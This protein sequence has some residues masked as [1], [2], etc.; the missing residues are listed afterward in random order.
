[1][2]L[3]QKDALELLFSPFWE[4]SQGGDEIETTLEKSGFTRR[5]M[6]GMWAT[7]RIELTRSEEE[8]HRSLRPTT[9]RMIAKGREAGISVKE[10]NGKTGWQALV[11]LR[12][13]LSA[14][15][16]VTPLSLDELASLDKFWLRNG[17][18]GTILIARH[19]GRPVGGVSIV[20]WNGTAFILSGGTSRSVPG[21][22]ANHLLL[23]EAIRWA[24][25]RG[26]RIFD[27][28]GFSMDARP[29]DELWGVNTFKR[30]FAQDR[31]PEKYVANHAFVPNMPL[32]LIWKAMKQYRH[33]IGLRGL[34]Q[35]RAR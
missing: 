31:A 24:K 4:L 16:H 5:R 14:K 7:L 19:D 30:G 28:G 32:Y 3:V 13:E 23:W 2:G 18:Q 21:L 10:E 35:E 17:Q 22:P 1:M 27:L 34:I 9:R 33:K 26:C 12:K 20:T 15:K 8:I 11:E 25:N 29:G 6:E